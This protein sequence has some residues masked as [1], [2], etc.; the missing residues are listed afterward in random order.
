[1]DYRD[2][3][4]KGISDISCEK[5]SRNVVRYFQKMKEGMQSGADT[6]LKN[7]WDEICVH[8]QRGESILFS[9]YLDTAR[10]YIHNEVEK[11]DEYIKKAIWIQ[12]DQHFDCQDTGEIPDA[13]IYCEDDIIEY[14]LH[15]FVLRE[16]ET[17]TNKRIEY[18]LWNM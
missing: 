4:I 17:W 1:M 6:S 11:L 3:I 18:Y 9:C 5:I 7:V 8:V 16:A 2:T 12:T 15:H 10:K 13:L 14:I